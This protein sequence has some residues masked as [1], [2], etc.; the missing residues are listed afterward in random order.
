MMD[1]GVINIIN[2]QFEKQSYYPY[3]TLKIHAAYN[4]SGDTVNMVRPRKKPRVTLLLRELQSALAKPI[5]YAAANS[6]IHESM[7]ALSPPAL[8]PARLPV[9]QPVPPPAL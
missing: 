2:N 5:I 6:V 8:Q 9:L 1:V 4:F 7:L 3:Q